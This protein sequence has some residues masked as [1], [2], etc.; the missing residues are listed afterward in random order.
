MEFEWDSDK[1]TENR[2]KHG[3]SF[4]QAVTLWDGIHMEVEEIARS[5]DGEKRS[6]T[7]GWVGSKIFVAIW[8]GRG[9]KIRL[10]SVRRAG[11]N[12]ENVFI[13]KIQE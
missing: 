2:R 7:M 9:E 11:K 3:I 8:T 10:I 5:E 4:E 1:N 12:E 6:A 13:K